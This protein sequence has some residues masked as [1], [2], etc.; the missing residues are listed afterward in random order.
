MSLVYIFWMIRCG[1]RVFYFG[2][3]CWV[4]RGGR[5]WWVGGG[6]VVMLCGYEII[7]V[8]FSWVFGRV[9]EFLCV[10]FFV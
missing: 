5:D 1:I 3:F 7:L 2:F 9:I 8:I 10:F 6:F 4:M